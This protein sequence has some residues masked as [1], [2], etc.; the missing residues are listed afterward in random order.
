V[1]ASNNRVGIGT[2]S[3]SQALD[4]VG[5]AEING[6]LQVDNTSLFVNA[7]NNRVGI[8]TTSPSQV[9]DVV[10]NAEIN[11]TAIVNGNANISGAVN[12]NGHLYGQRTAFS[13]YQDATIFL[14]SA[15][16]T[17][18]LTFSDITDPYGSFNGLIFTAPRSGLYFFSTSVSF[19]N[20]NGD[21]DTMWMGFSVN[22]ASPS[23]QIVINPRAFTSSGR[24]QTYSH[25]IILNLI[26][27]QNVRVQL[28]SVSSTTDVRVLERTFTGFYLGDL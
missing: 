4:V 24:E 14:S 1:N 3:P 21:D 22:N 8:R 13:A 17:F 15:S 27:G 11:G 19:D 2:T 10:G 9:L 25:T 23:S 18:N 28:L 5:S 6:N 26:A 7:S 20:G 16:A 12:A